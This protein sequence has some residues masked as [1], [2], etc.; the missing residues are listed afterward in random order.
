MAEKEQKPSEQPA[1]SGADPAEK[2]SLLRRFTPTQWAMIVVGS[3]V[4]AHLLLLT[5]WR[6]SLPTA[7]D[8]TTSE[9]ALG[10]YQF[11]SHA[12]RPNELGIRQ[13]SFDLHVHLLSGVS[14]PAHALLEGRK[15][16]VQQDVEE[17]LRQAHPADFEDPTLTELKRQ[18]QEKINTALEMRSV[19]QV[20][21]T[22]LSLQGRP[23][24]LEGDL[25]SPEPAAPFVPQTVGQATAPDAGAG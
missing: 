7:A 20:I 6:Y 4:L 1:A 15:F 18:L 14:N 9:F 24:A 3:S 11:F 17:L 22:N 12:Q 21:I 2:T 8:P 16:R 19:D 5:A 23:K 25:L 13:A 10:Q